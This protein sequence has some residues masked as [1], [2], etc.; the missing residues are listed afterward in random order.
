MTRAILCLHPSH[1]SSTPAALDAF[2][3]QNTAI[4]YAGSA[5]STSN[6]QGFNVAVGY[7]RPK[8]A[9]V[10]WLLIVEQTHEEAFEPITSLRNI[11][12][13]CIFGTAGGIA[14][15]ILPMAHFSVLPIR[16]LRDATEKSVQPPYYTPDGS[17]RSETMDGVADGADE[18]NG[19][20][21]SRGSRKKIHVC[22]AV[23][24]HQGGIGQKPKQKSQKMHEGGFS[25]SLE[26]CRT[27][28][29]LLRTN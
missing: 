2:T 22:D 26:K 5:L 16:R 13:A 6:E 7:A 1:F 24:T 12:L 20:S 18:E 25:K 4:N 21:S 8:S 28:S 14:I 29:T 19:G 11:L 15:L 27:A 10:D 17:I 3:I 23:E 9:F